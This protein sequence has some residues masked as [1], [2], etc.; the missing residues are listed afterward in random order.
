L[1]DEKE[2]VFNVL[3]AKILVAC[4]QVDRLKENLYLSSDSHLGEAAA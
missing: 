1:T 4:L 3:M 2:I